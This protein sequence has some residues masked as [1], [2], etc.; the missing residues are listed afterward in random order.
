M[1]PLSVK[2]FVSPLRTLLPKNARTVVL[3]FT[4]DL[5]L[6]NKKINLL[7]T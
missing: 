1:T 5:H 7:N 6:I 4:W 3:A 2:D